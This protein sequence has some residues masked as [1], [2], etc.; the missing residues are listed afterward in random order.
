M[1]FKNSEDK[2]LQAMEEIKAKIEVSLKGKNDANDWL[3]LSDVLDERYT[4]QSAHELWNDEFMIEI[5]QDLKVRELEIPQDKILVAV[6]SWGVLE[7]L[8]ED[9]SLDDD[10]LDS[11][12]SQ[13]EID[14]GIPCSI[15]TVSSDKGVAFLERLTEDD[16]KS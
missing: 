6:F 10:A 14:F 4:L 3:Q 5:N 16:K 13:I 9:N 1:V 15:L 7:L 2:I 11:L 8:V 12:E